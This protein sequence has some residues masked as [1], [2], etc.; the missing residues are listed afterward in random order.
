MASSTYFDTCISTVLCYN[1][2]V[3]DMTD[4]TRFTIDELCERTGTTRRT[5]RYYVAEGLLPPP[6]GRGRGGFYGTAHAERLGRI[7]EL[8]A[9]GHALE[10]IRAMF[11]DDSG[12]RA[13]GTGAAPP[14]P[15]PAEPRELRAVYR[16]A[17]GVDLSVRRDAEE[18]NPSRIRE[19]LRV[20]RTLFPEGPPDR[21]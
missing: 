12:T 7:R 17:D 9:A 20:A 13:D 14:P 11:M 8:R 15:P 1:K 4:E 10:T 2:F 16:I 18:N 19:L 5:V 3:S 6:A 21:R